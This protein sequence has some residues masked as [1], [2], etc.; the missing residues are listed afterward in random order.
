MPIEVA[1]RLPF[2]LTTSAQ[3]WLALLDRTERQGLRLDTLRP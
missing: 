1:S 2:T 3:E